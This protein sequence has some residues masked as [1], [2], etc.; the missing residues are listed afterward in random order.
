MLVLIK[1]KNIKN[2][3]SLLLPILLITLTA[4]GYGSIYSSVPTNDG[5]STITIDDTPR[6][7]IQ[8]T[9]STYDGKKP[10]PLM[11]IFH[12]WTMSATDQIELSDLRALAESNGLYLFIL[13]VLYFKVQRIGMLVHGQ[14]VALQMI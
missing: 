5:A 10:V 2:K 9:P 14:R 12:G 8:H 13:K 4:I 3:K 11:L 6:E 1:M 7:Y